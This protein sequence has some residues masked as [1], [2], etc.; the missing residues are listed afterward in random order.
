MAFSNNTC[1]AMV[2][3]QYTELKEP[4]IDIDEQYELEENYYNDYL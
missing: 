3:L 4:E 2:I 1:F